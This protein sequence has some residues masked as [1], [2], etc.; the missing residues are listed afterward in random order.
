MFNC[1]MMS[2]LLLVVLAG[3]GTGVSTDTL[4]PLWTKQINQE[5]TPMMT[6]VFAPVSSQVSSELIFYSDETWDIPKDELPNYKY[7]LQHAKQTKNGDLNPLLVIHVKLN[8]PFDAYPLNQ[9]QEQIWS[10]KEQLKIN[11]V[12]A[13]KIKL[14]YGNKTYFNGSLQA[15][16]SPSDID[17]FYNIDSKG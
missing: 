1:F 17:Q 16:T 4:R 9:L 14:E 5:I 7:G 8:E 11:G 10:A 13:G 6:D 12:N 15:M 2:L 3:C